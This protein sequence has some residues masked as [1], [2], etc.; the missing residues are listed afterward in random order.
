[1]QIKN[2]DDLVSKMVEEM[3]AKDI[4]VKVDD[5]DYVRNGAKY[6]EWERKGVP[7]RIE[8]GPRDAKAESCVFKYRVGDTEKKVVPIVGIGDIV[9]SGLANLQAFLLD[10]S[11]AD[12]NKAIRKGED[13]SYEEMS[14][15]LRGDEASSF[16]GAGLFL[17]PWK[18][19]SVNEDKIKDNCKATIRCYPTLENERGDFKGKKCF[20]SGE[21]ADRMALFG[22]AF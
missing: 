13:V 7:L 2:V 3:R 15:L 20:Y 16:D 5:R 19:D 9:E 14:N 8:I 22:R 17:V 4:R 11:E 6:F 1:M 21:D 18:C 12:L 10:R